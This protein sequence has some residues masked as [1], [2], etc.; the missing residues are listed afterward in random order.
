MNIKKQFLKDAISFIK[1]S[2]DINEILDFK[3]SN[4]LMVDRMY[5]LIYS[6]IIKYI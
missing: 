1:T 2:N 3:D 4:T 6:S 5:L